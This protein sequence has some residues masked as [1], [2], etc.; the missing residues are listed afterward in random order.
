M[1]SLRLTPEAV[2]TSRERDK[3]LINADLHVHTEYSMDSATTLDQVMKSCLKRGINC[4]AIADHGTHLTWTWF[5]GS[6]WQERSAD[7]YAAA[8]DVARTLAS[9]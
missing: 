8:A 2:N 7:L 5:I 3:S 4:V 1:I 9:R 6:G